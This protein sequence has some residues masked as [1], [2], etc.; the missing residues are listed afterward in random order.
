MEVASESGL[1]LLLPGQLFNASEGADSTQHAAPDV[2]KPAALAFSPY[3]FPNQNKREKDHFQLLYAISRL[4]LCSRR[5][6][7]WYIRVPKAAV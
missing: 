6:P 2:H 4:H 7:L 1:P 3:A 5:S